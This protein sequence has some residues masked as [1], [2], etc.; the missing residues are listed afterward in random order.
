MINEK[1]T[2]ALCLAG[3][4][5]LMAVTVL[6]TSFSLL[7]RFVTRKQNMTPD[8]VS[9]ALLAS[10]VLFSVSYLVAA[11]SPSVITTVKILRSST[12]STPWK[13]MLSYTSLF[14]FIGMLS[15]F[16]IN[17]LSWFLFTRLTKSVNELEEIRKNNIATGILTGAIVVGIT[18]MVKE[19]VVYLVETLV[20]YPQIPGL[21]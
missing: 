9:Y 8:N 7:Y 20:P 17:L 15:A 4:S 12:G 5:L 6:Y 13:D 11:A 2:L 3:A 16:L 10:S 19:S 18:L 21:Y 1:L 14:M